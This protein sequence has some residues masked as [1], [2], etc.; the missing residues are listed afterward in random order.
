MSLLKENFYFSTNTEHSGS[1]SVDVSLQQD[2][3]FNSRVC[4]GSLQVS[5]LPPT[6]QKHACA[7]K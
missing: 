6:D 3:K 2:H 1:D 4:V 5:Q 7:E